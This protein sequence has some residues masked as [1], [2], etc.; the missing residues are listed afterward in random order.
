VN[1]PQQAAQHQHEVAVALLPQCA[2]AMDRSWAS[3]STAM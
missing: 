1:E 2:F 3:G